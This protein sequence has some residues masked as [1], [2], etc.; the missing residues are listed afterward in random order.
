MDGFYWDELVQDSILEPEAVVTG[1]KTIVNLEAENMTVSGKLILGSSAESRSVE[2][3]VRDDRSD[4]D[5]HV[6]ENVLLRSP[7]YVEELTAQ[8]QLLSRMRYFRV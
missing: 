5:V 7:L 2:E 1:V 8:G 3:F 4:E 6:L